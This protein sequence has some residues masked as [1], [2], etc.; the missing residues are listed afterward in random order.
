MV[1]LG[2]DTVEPEYLLRCV[3]GSSVTLTPLLVLT[4]DTL[5]VVGIAVTLHGIVMGSPKLTLYVLCG[6]ETD[7]VPK[8]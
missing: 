4:H 2:F 8:V 6:M 5:L 1:R 7:G 3:A